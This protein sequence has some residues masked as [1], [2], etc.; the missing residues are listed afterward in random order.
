MR[1]LFV[2]EATGW[3]GGA[4]QIWLTATRL[5]ARGHQVAVACTD[6][7]ELSSRLKAAAVPVLPF[8]PRQDYDLFGARHLARLAKRWGADLIHSHHPRA[9]ALAL[10]ATVFGMM[11][12]IVV[13]RRVI[14]PIGK[15]PFSR[16]KYSSTRVS[17]YIAVC[18][19]AGT[20][21]QAAGVSAERISVIPSGVD[22]AR[23]EPTRA[24]RP[25]M[26]DRKPLIVTMVGHYAPIKGHEVL[27]EAIPLVLRELPEVRFR[28]AGRDTEGL[29]DKA[30]RFGLSGK[31]QLLG[32]RRDVPEL[33]ADSHLYV[34]PSLQEGIGTALIE[35][36][37][38]LVPVVA[39]RVGGL[40][41]VVDDGRTG[42]LVPPGD[43]A[44][45][46]DAIVASLRNPRQT[47][48]MAQAGYE[49]ARNLFSIDQ[50]VLRL[51]A[52]YQSLA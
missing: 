38:G 16:V 5:I 8:T 25:A 24:A 52:L 39:S 32:E 1:L 42:T 26:N 50:V 23:W 37:A 43:P 44:A 28:L 6:G 10:L 45:L 14:R 46:A 31:V 36:Q 29:R 11:A 22:F 13:T 48:T 41:H 19:A 18:D 49:R 17:R 4:N 21:L 27:L 33:L 51:E 12:P 3:S 34:M 2:S 15:N 35:A 7:A 9:H 40:P 20:E 30:N 47:E